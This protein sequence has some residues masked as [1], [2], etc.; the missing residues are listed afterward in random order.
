MSFSRVVS[1][2]SLGLA[3]A[4]TGLF[5]FL[6][7]AGRCESRWVSSASNTSYQIPAT[8]RAARFVKSRTISVY[9]APLNEPDIPMPVILS[10]TSGSIGIASWMSS[11]AGN[12]QTLFPVLHS[13]Q[14]TVQLWPVF[15]TS[16]A[17]VAIGSL[18]HFKRV[19]AQRG[20][21]VDDEQ[22]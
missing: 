14:L 8:W 10:Q 18:R 9:N 20:F 15:L 13:W 11:T 17:I 7:F 1:A 5:L 21:P 19:S 3:L 4:S 16:L 22:T 6:A 2:I 12:P